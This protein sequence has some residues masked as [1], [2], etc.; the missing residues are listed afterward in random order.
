MNVDYDI[1][2]DPKPETVVERELTPFEQMLF[3]ESMADHLLKLRQIALIHIKDQD[4]TW[5]YYGDNAS[6][7]DIMIFMKRYKKDIVGIVKE[8]NYEISED[9]VYYW[10]SMINEFMKRAMYARSKYLKAIKKYK[11]ETKRYDNR[12]KTTTLAKGV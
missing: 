1:P 6:I 2:D 5:K 9:D 12:S 10:W 3:K 8:I 4:R 11:E 7:D